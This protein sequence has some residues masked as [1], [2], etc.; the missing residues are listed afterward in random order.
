[1]KKL[2]S[3]MVTIASTG[4]LLTGCSSFLTDHADDY[5]NGVEHSETLVA[6]DGSSPLEDKLVIPNE[7]AVADLQE[8]K[9]FVA[10]RAPFLYQSMAKVVMMEK[11]ASVDYVFPADIRQSKKIVEDFSVSFI[12]EEGIVE[13]N[14][15]NRVTTIPTLLTQQSWWR[16]TWSKITRVYPD[17]REF[18]FDILPQDNGSTLVRMQTR[19]VSQDDNANDWVSPAE[20]P[21]SYALAV[22]LWG[23]IGRKLDQNSSYLSD[24]KKQPEPSPVWINGAGMFAAYL[25]KKVSLEQVNQ[26][27]SN[28]GLYLIGENNQLSAV[29]EDDI[30]R[31]GDIVAL[32]IPV[33]NGKTQ[34]LFNV[35]RRDLDNV[36]WEERVYPYK[37]ERQAA[38]DF[39]VIDVSATENPQLT[40]YFFAKK[41]LK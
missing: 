40:S 30:A 28:A 25:G 12:N 6:P 3:T 7:D 2:T 26:K 32:E 29:A 34:K 41:F 22:K 4:L 31:V 23:T 24:R 13:S 21:N 1:M 16:S 36:S 10:P 18:S 38:G 27:I 5:Q 9:E 37:V 15:D 33:G 17:K 14:S 35:R 19:E 20:D 11:E 39:L 8:K